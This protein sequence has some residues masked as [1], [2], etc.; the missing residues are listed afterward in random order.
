MEGDIPWQKGFFL[1]SMKEKAF[2]IIPVDE[3]S[4]NTRILVVTTAVE[5]VAMIGV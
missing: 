5:D 3:S 2:T 1:E 4:N